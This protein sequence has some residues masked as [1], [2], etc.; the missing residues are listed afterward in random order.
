MSQ[1]IWTQCGGRRNCR[2]WAGQPW[3]VVEA[4]HVVST[5]KLVDSD[6]EQQLLEEL[7][8]TAKP[9]VP[10]G[11]EG[12]HYL[13]FTP[14]RH[15]PLRHG[16]RFGRRDEPSLFYASEEEATALA[17]VA[18]Y[19]LVFL[20]GTT[21][22]IDR[23][24]VELSSFQVEVASDLAIDL[25]APPFSEHGLALT[26]PT[27]YDATQ[28]L[29]S[30]MRADGIEVVRYVSARAPAKGENIALFSPGAFTKTTPGVP[31]TWLCVTT[32]AGVEFS[33][34]DYFQ[35]ESHT[36]P[37]SLFEVAGSLPLPSA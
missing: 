26:S 35:R 11:C 21:A 30:A 32:P 2:S 10:P 12:L 16:S 29:G 37:R 1:D 23:I 7:I 19:R 6:D 13:L 3:R 22:P 18:Y 33:R 36:F 34:K 14:F 31:R 17:E 27:R 25:S 9:P 8:D 5:R 15:P 24:F 20:E 4:Q 28:A